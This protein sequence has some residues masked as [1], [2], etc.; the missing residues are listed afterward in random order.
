MTDN[1]FQKVVI[2]QCSNFFLGLS[3]Y[4]LE[5]LDQMNKGGGLNI[6]KKRNT[7]GGSSSANTQSGKAPNRRSKKNK[8]LVDPNCPRKPPTS[9]FQF[10]ASRKEKV[11]EQYPNFSATEIAQQL[12]K[13]WRELP[14]ER[15]TYFKN[16]YKDM[17]ADY[18]L[19]FADYQEKKVAVVTV[20]TKAKEVNVDDELLKKRDKVEDENQVEESEEAQGSDDEEGEGDDNDDDDDDNDDDND[21]EEEEASDEE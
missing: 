2:K 19:R 17:Y 13:E 7:K 14:E 10:C 6:A 1:E 12:S 20:P 21:D 5:Y 16:K 15:S 18:K 8:D 3:E 4:C 9:F 11:K